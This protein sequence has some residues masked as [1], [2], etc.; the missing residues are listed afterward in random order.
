[1]WEGQLSWARPSPGPMDAGPAVLPHSQ[2]G[3]GGWPR[4]WGPCPRS[5]EEPVLEVR[6]HLNH[7][8]T[9]SSNPLQNP[10]E[11][12]TA[13]LSVSRLESHGTWTLGT[14]P[15]LPPSTAPNPRWEVAGRPRAAQGQGRSPPG[16]AP[17]QA[18][19]H[20]L[21]GQLV[22]RAVACPL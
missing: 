8:D 22:S 2:T 6:S 5:Y 21:Q 11:S 1:M 3:P 15:G 13:R 7:W 17:P 18:P 12:R 16:V 10:E 4:T 19:L 9:G 14:W 20:S